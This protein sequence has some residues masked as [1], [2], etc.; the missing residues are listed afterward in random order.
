MILRKVVLFKIPWDT[1]S[2]ID[3]GRNLGPGECANPKY[4]MDSARESQEICQN[5]DIMAAVAGIGVARDRAGEARTASPHI[6]LPRLSSS[7]HHHNDNSSS[8]DLLN[9]TA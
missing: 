5:H 8:P 4:I 3:A 2:S 6:A 1:A 7:R 9:L